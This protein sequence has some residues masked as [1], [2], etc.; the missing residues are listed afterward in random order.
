MLSIEAVFSMKISTWE[1][2]D[3]EKIRFFWHCGRGTGAV[4]ARSWYSWSSGGRGA[5][6]VLV[7]ALWRAWC[8]NSQRLFVHRF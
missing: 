6:V 5:G 8:G 7:V 2:A 3:G 4:D 1:G